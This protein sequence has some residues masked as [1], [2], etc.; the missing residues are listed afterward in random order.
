[1]EV[2]QSGYKPPEEWGSGWVENANS[3]SD[4]SAANK[5]GRFDRWLHK[6]TSH[7]QD[8]SGESGD[9]RELREKRQTNKLRR[10][11]GQLKPVNE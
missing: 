8:R 2:G 7:P 5:Q 3:S 10:K 9:L 1:M 6:A 11:S 4:A